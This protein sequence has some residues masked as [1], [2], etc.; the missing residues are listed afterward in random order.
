MAR[1][2]MSFVSKTMTPVADATNMTDNGYAGFLQGANSTMRLA[3]SE[4]YIGGESPSAS[5][6]CTMVLGRDST[7]AAT[8]IGGNFNAALDATATQPTLAVYGCVSTTKPQRSA[9]V[10]H[11]LQ[12]SLNTYGGIA[13]WQARHG[14]EIITI[15][16]AAGFGEVSLSS[17]TGAGLVSGHILYEV[18]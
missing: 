4:V 8:G 18:V 15:G 13:R 6:P 16:N 14:E 10:G 7:V 12:L 11:L 1:Y 2:S 17:I 3:I 5:T 9:T